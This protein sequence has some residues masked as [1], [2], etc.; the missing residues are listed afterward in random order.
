MLLSCPIWSNTLLATGGNPLNNKLWQQKGIFSIG[1]LFNEN[2]L[3]PFS[4]VKAE[5]S[6]PE[7]AF[8]AYLQIKSIISKR[9]HDSVT[10]A[11]KTELDQS[12]RLAVIKR[13]TTSSIYKL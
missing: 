11:F 3:R 13:G 8:L 6:L 5:F 12:L 9:L 1:Q 4:D 7:S 2:G 10:P